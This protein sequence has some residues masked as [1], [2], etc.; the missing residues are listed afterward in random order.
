MPEVDG[1]ELI[2]SVRASEIYANLPVLMITG[3]DQALAVDEAYSAGAT[4]FLSKPINWELFTRSVRFVLQSAQ[5]EKELRHA[6][7]MAF[8]AVKLK[9]SILSNLTHEMRTPLNHIIGFADLLATQN[10]IREDNQLL[11][12]VENIQS[13]GHRM[14]EL[15]LDMLFLS[16]AET[17]GITLKPQNCEPYVLMQQ[18][19]DRCESAA[20]KKGITIQIYNSDEVL[21]LDGELLKRALSK[22]LDNAIK[23]AP[24]QSHVQLGCTVSPHT[25]TPVFFVRDQGPG[26][27]ATKLSCL[28]ESFQ[29]VDMNHNRQHDG[30]GI[31]LRVCTLIASAFNGEIKYTNLQEGGFMVTLAL[32]SSCI[33][34]P[35]QTLAAIA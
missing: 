29:Q 26:V 16:M 19:K 17:E 11:P 28:G 5:T 12:F 35:N 34:S 21:N 20:Q 27:P 9:Q 31:G 32:P 22:L 3:K 14:L 13:S 23:F 33:V 15:I 25:D 30:I 7:D 4:S 24:A 6:K 8:S 18:V 10:N 1:L 2:K